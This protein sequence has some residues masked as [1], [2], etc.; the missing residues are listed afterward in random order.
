MNDH[1]ALVKCLRC[2]REAR[3]LK[4]YQALQFTIAATGAG[5]SSGIGIETAR[6]LHETGAHLFLTARDAA[7]IESV[8]ADILKAGGSGKID[9]L[10][11][12]LSSLES[13]RQC[14]DAF[15]AK[16]KQLNALVLNAGT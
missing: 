15:L 4:F 8:K 10:H 7:K 6:A 13:V 9:V 1:F 14:A 5:C 3:V 12:D 2:F 11:L 16:S